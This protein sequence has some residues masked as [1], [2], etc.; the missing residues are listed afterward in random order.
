METPQTLKSVTDAG[1]YLPTSR[2]RLSQLLL[3]AAPQMLKSLSAMLTFLSAV[4]AIPIV[5]DFNTSAVE[6]C[7]R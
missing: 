2:W 1:A 4:R 3:I 7:F 5:G 6:E